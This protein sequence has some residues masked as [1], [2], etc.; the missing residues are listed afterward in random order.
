MPNHA[1]LTLS[2]PFPR[3]FENLSVN[4]DPFP[5]LSQIYFENL[6]DPF[7]PFPKNHA[8]I[9]PFPPFPKLGK[10][11]IIQNALDPFP[12]FPSLRGKVGKGWGGLGR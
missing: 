2:H 4:S 7:P 10:G 1:Q 8:Q 11:S 3:Y 12:L 9:D 5:T 6:S